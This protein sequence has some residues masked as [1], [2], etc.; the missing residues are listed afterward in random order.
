MIAMNLHPIDLVALSV[1]AAVVVNLL[2]K[3]FCYTFRLYVADNYIVKVH[4]RRDAVE[5][6][7]S[8]AVK[9]YSENGAYILAMKKFFSTMSISNVQRTTVTKVC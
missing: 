7:I 3:L 9:A 6:E 8:Y 4:F 1:A 5:H 2:W